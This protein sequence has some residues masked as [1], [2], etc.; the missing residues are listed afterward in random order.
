[1]SQNEIKSRRHFTKEQKSQIL[2]ELKTRAT[3]ITQ[4]AREKGIHPVTLHNWKRKMRMSQNSNEVDVRAILEEL[5]KLKKENN[6]LK[7]VIGELSIDKLILKTSN[8]IYKKDIIKKKLFMAS[9]SS[10]KSKKKK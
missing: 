6:Q 2:E 10:K 5:E 9:K 3:T 4:L 7:E 8:D 1:M